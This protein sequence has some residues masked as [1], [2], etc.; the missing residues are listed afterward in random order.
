MQTL[1]QWGD[2][3]RTPTLFRKA[4]PLTDLLL[5]T[6][7]LVA[8]LVTAL[9]WNDSPPAPMLPRAGFSLACQEDEVAAPMVDRDPTH[10]LTWSC[11]ARESIAP[12][13]DNVAV[14]NQED[15]P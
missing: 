6:A 5:L 2:S 11:Q 1:E 15:R 14:Y 9:T 3:Q 12:N 10:G 7:A 8:W 4:P 13:G